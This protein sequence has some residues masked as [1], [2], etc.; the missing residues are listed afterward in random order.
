MVDSN[1]FHVVVQV[2]ECGT[3]FA[4][5]GCPADCQSIPD[6]HARV[7]TIFRFLESE[8][9]DR[10]LW[11]STNASAASWPTRSVETSEG[12]S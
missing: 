6:K 12:E 2:P 11:K 1:W 10:V 3:L 5:S 9:A 7:L 4:A 8:P